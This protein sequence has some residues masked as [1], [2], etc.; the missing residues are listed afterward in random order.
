MARRRFDHLH[1]ELSVAVGRLISRYALWLH[2]KEL[3]WDPEG[4]SR[5]QAVLFCDQH[6]DGFLSTRGL[7]LA[8]SR[9]A[10]LR[11]RIRG[12]DAAHPTPYETLSRL[13]GA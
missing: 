7:A 3:G 4:L 1:S 9:R 8:G 6:L 13:G 10:R 12:F 5:C 2:L 11:R